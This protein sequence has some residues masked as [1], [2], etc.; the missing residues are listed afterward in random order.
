MERGKYGRAGCFGM[1]KQVVLLSIFL[2]SLRVG[3]IHGQ[4]HYYLSLDNGATN[5]K[6]G[7]IWVRSSRW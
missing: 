7:R 6:V 1:I 4:N 5:V 2:A 3:L